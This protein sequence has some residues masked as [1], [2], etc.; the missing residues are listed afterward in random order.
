MKAGCVPSSVRPPPL[1]LTT[2][3]CSRGSG[4]SC[5]RAGWPGPP[6][7]LE[8]TGKLVK[9]LQRL[10][11]NR[12]LL[13]ERYG[14]I[15]APLARSECGQ[16]L[17]E[18]SLRGRRDRFSEFQGMSIGLVGSLGL[19]HCSVRPAKGRIPPDQPFTVDTMLRRV[20]SF[21]PLLDLGHHPFIERNRLGML[22]RERQRSSLR[23]GSFGVALL[24]GG[25]G[26]PQ[27]EQDC[28]PS[29]LRLRGLRRV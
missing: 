5:R 6:E 24:P 25:N 10:E 20:R 16:S 13:A 11:D 29:A 21:L 22:A 4:T 12:C 18:I 9:K 7:G 14:L 1:T 17:V 19:P 8:R 23:Q 3:R 2:G 15:V 28:H 27:A 26:E